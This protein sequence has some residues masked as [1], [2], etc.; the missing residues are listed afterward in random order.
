V[1]FS[2]CDGFNLYYR[3]L[4]KTKYKWL[5]LEI[6]VKSLLD[7]DNDIQCIRYFTAPVSGKLDP[8]QPIRQQRYLQALSTIPCMSFHQGFRRWIAEHHFDS[9]G[10]CHIGALIHTTTITLVVN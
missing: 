7:P 1:G 8:G 2:S 4:K 3:A 6:L 9:H 10:H 5:N